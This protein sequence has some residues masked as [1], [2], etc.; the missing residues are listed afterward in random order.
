MIDKQSLS[1]SKS[2]LGIYKK[3]L[4]LGVLSST[5]FLTACGAD[6]ETE[7]PARMVPVNTQ[8]V[9]TG[10]IATQVSFAGQ[11][12]PQDN[13]SVMGRIPGGMVDEV[14]FN[15]GDFVNA[16]DPLFT[17]DLVDINNQIANLSAQLQTAEAAVRA[18]QTGV[19]VA[20]G[21]GGVQQQQIQ[22][23]SSVN[24]A[25]TAVTNATIAI[26]QSEANVNQA[27]LSLDQ[28][29]NGYNTASQNLLDS[30]T[31]FD[32]GAMSR[33]QLDQA[34]TVAENARIGLEQAINGYNIATNA[35]TQART[36]LST[37]EQSLA[38]AQSS[39]QI[40]TQTLPSD[41]QAQA[42]GGLE[43]AMAQRNAVQVQLNVA[44][45][46]L[47]DATVRSPISGVVS[48]R[49]VEPRTMLT[50]GA[51]F[52]IVSENA[53]SITTEVTQSVVNMVHP[54]DTVS[55]A[56][57][58]AGDTDF[59]GQVITVSPGTGGNRTFTVEVNV[60]NPQGLIRPGMFAQV[61]FTT[62][63]RQNAVVIPRQAVLTQGAETVVYLATNGT[64][65]RQAVQTGLD[66]G[67]EVE[68]TAGLMPGDE[69]I[70][71]GQNFV[72]H[73]VGLNIIESH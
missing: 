22:A 24:Q 9:S 58:A 46:S 17:M 7:T 44:T 39:Y 26:E 47:A 15:V 62:Q 64:A 57:P 20:T 36:G 68:I 63:A 65:S 12:H 70:V 19:G 71:T 54:G 72:N 18:A 48:A 28:A 61:Y 51:P 53:V 3:F 4:A 38:D 30:R 8:L 45:S 55:V 66:T 31:L 34:E 11:V 42:Q 43:Q 6:I 13:L 67:L 1:P 37:A 14:F 23:A 52:T 50:G 73:G 69:L 32:A 49:N 16:G 35:L 41:N 5:F 33:M 2:G 59:I 40:I 10:D 29:Q 60:D 56:I 27:R 25:Q 21:G